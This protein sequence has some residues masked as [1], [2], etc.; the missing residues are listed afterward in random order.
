ML[1]RLQ[2][3]TKTC[4][5]AADEDRLA[6]LASAPTL[7]MYR[8]FLARIHGFEAPVEVALVRTPDVDDWIDVRGRTQLRLLRADLAALGILDPA[9]LPRCTSVPALAEP[10]AA[11]G[12]AYVLERNARLH[13]VIERHLRAAL[14]EPMKHAGSYLGGQARSAGL[15]WRELGDTLDRLARTLH[16]AD[17]IVNAARAAFRVQHGWYTLAAPSQRVA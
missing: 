17:A 4:H 1:A 14:P 6:I 10:A 13:G 16:L 9:R 11:L 15:R 2:R 3:E 8:Q 7:A 5:A 12:W